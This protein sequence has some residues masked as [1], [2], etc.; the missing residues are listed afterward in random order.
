MRHRRGCDVDISWRRVAAPP[1]LRRGQSLET[2]RVAAAAATWTFRGDELRRRR[3]CDVDVRPRRRRAPQVRR[4]RRP[5]LRFHDVAEGRSTGEQLRLGRQERRAAVHR[6]GR[7]RLSRDVRRL[8]VMRRRVLRFFV[9]VQEQHTERAR[10]VSV[11]AASPRPVRLAGKDC[12]WVRDNSRVR[13]TGSALNGCP[14][15]CGT[16]ATP[17]PS[18]EPTEDPWALLE[19]ERAAHQATKAELYLCRAAR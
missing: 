2:I 1:Q 10:R 16:C 12:D 18:A 11:A 9:L 19:R 5:M 4:L 8:S 7:R 15:S 3:G 14:V 17:E 6:R 13:C